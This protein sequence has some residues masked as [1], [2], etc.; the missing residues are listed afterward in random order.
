MANILLIANLNCDRILQLGSALTTGGR[1]HYQDMGR[2]LGGGGAN[3]G[4]GLLFA[5]HR[6]TLVSQIGNDETADWLLAEAS[7]R[8]LDC[9]LLQRNDLS[10]P[11]LLLLMTPDA[12]RTIIRP[13]RPTFTLGCAPDF[14]QWQALYINSSAHGAVLWSAEAL[15]VCL[16]VAQLP[17]DASIRPCHILIASLSDLNKQQNDTSAFWQ[18][19]QKIAGPKLR[20][21]IVTDGEKGAH[22]YSATQTQHIAAI[23]AEVID[24]T[25][26]GDAFAAGV[27]DALV[28]GE[29]ILQAMAQGAQWSAIAVSTQSSVPGERLQRYIQH[30]P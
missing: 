17:K 27:I 21:F 25:G 30:A 22:V 20:Y 2:R 15:K 13:Q 19:A 14:T 3:T 7:L 28:R 11:E 26:A 23:K 10:T 4:M 12:E 18:Y 9:H 5:G 1:H 6:V 16:V 29:N 24:T 8:G